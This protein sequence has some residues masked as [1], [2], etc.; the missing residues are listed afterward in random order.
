MENAEQAAHLAGL[1]ATASRGKRGYGVIKAPAG[2][3]GRQIGLIHR[4]L[5]EQAA[6]VRLHCP[7]SA[8]G[9]LLRM[10]AH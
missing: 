5:L 1:A 7:A 10:H 8:G 6:R 3:A 9:V 4:A 2:G